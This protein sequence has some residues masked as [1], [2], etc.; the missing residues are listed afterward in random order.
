MNWPKRH[1]VNLSIKNQELHF[2]NK[3]Q[4]LNKLKMENTN[5]YLVVRMMI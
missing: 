1:E 5:N 4:K 2:S 3:S